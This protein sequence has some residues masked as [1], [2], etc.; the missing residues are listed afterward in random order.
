M[1]LRKI[2]VAVDSSGMSLARVETALNLA[3]HSDARVTALYVV[4]TEIMPVASTSMHDGWYMES[5]YLSKS[6]E[7]A[8]ETAETIEKA[9]RQLAETHKKELV[10]QQEEGDIASHICLTAR[11][12]DIL[13]LGKPDILTT[14]KAYCEAI[15]GVLLDAGKPCLVV[16][17]VVSWFHHKPG[18]I[19]VAW[20]GSRESS[21]AVHG[22][23]PLLKEAESVVVVS[24]CKSSDGDD[25]LTRYNSDLVDYLHCHAINATSHIINNGSFTAGH[26][27]SDF[28]HELEAD[29]M[30]MGSYGHSRFRE[31][32][33]GG[34]TRFVLEHAEI[35]ILFAH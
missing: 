33:L 25:K 26:A 22:A 30:V 16:P 28:A 13:L 2:L 6:R 31:A 9:C 20:D 32:I 14:P 17:D 7:Q 23:M 29:L 8:L 19:L 12:H 1:Q 27:I 15:N 21:Q 4:Y 10:W 24:V 11:Y 18:K 5:E 35:P 3:S 34:A